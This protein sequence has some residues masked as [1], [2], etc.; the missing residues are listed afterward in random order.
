MKRRTKSSSPE[1][2]ALGKP[3]MA[4]W[5]RLGAELSDGVFDR[6]DSFEAAL[7]AALDVFTAEERAAL[8][9]IITGLAADGDARDA[10]AASGAEIGFGGPRDARMALLMLLEAAKAK[11]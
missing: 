5:R 11:A 9:G 1:P 7:G 8:R 6:F 4:L 3:E 10:W 2:V